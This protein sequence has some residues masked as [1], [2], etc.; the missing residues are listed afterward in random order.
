MKRHVFIIGL[1]VLL[2]ALGTASFLYALAPRE[3]GEAGAVRFEITSGEGAYRI[4]ER[5]MQSGLIRSATGFYL[6]SLATGAA[7]ELKPGAYE[8]APR[9]SAYHMARELAAGPDPDREITVREG[10]T[11]FEI[12][13][14]LAEKG[15]LPRGALLAYERSS[16]RNLEGYLFPDTYRFYVNSAAPDVV[17]KF[18]AN[19]R[20]KAAPLL[21]GDEGGLNQRLL[22]ASLLEKEVPD[23][24]ERRVVA[25]ILLK[26]IRNDL[27]LQVD[28]TLCYIKQ[29]DAGD[30]VPCYPLIALDFK[31]KSPYNTY[32]NKE[33]PPG[34]IASPGTGALEAA[35]APRDSSYWY[36]LSD[37]ATGKTI[38]A[39]TL[40]EH[41]RNR[42]KYLE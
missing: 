42:V 2:A 1:F 41:N 20:K 33:W 19:F 36:Y 29:L 14:L 12:D 6:V 22:L 4:A 37:P 8:L 27:P 17:A 18:D 35:R 16:G 38:F 9:M 3:G 13:A 32:L 39:T 10:M 15:I 25:G 24:E 7:F 40:D 34:P 5:L 31:N 26:R 30:A 11:K 28:A 21:D 23:Q